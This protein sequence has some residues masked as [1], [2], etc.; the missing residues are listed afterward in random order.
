[1][2]DDRFVAEDDLNELGVYNVD[3]NVYYGRGHSWQNMPGNRK[4]IELIK[5]QMDEYEKS[6]DKTKTSITRE[7]VAAIKGEQHGKFLK[8]ENGHWVEMGEECARKK[9]AQAMRDQ[10]NKRKK[11]SQPNDDSVEENGVEET[12]IFSAITDIFVDS[13]WNIMR[14]EATENH[15]LG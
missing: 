4:M 3:F 1:M 11:S 7:I 8:V 2:S 15:D 6:S 10:I 5:A 9:V 14:A 12:R 13:D